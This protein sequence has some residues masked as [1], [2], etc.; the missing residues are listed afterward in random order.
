FLCECS[1]Y[2][3]ASPNHLSYK[4]LQENRSRLECKKLVLTHLGE[5]MLKRRE[6]LEVACAEDGMTIEI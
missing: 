4:T 1:F 6:Q 5:E 2:D 3:Q